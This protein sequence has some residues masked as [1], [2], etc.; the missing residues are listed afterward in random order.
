MK[1]GLGN[2]DIY[3]IDVRSAQERVFPGRIPGSVHV[4]LLDLAQAFTAM[5]PEE[6]EAQ[7]DFKRPLKKDPKMIVSTCKQGMRARQAAEVLVQAGYHNVSVYDGSFSDW[8][9]Q[10]GQYID[11]TIDQ[12]ML[13]DFEQMKQACI[14]SMLVIDVRNPGELLDPGRIPGTKNVPCKYASSRGEYFDKIFTPEVCSLLE[15]LM[16]IMISERNL[17]SLCQHG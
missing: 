13:I 7:Y 5:T 3:L 9:G 1:Q 16:V 10:G 12:E 2:N 17:E 15:I 14:Q 11:G 6:F 8:T 4:P